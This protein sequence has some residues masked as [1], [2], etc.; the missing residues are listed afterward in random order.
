VLEVRPAEGDEKKNG[1]EYRVHYKGWK[2][3]Y[4]HPTSLSSRLP[5]YHRASHGPSHVAPHQHFYLLTPP[6]QHYCSFTHIS[7]L[8]L[9][10]HPRSSSLLPLILLPG[11]IVD[12]SQL[13]RLGS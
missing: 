10:L 9:L 3:T 8:K 2:N 5:I 4:V 1:F 7:P 12:I 11:L 13:G 6:L